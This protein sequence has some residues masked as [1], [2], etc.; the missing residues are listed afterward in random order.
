MNNYTNSDLLVDYIDNNLSLEEKIKVEA[1]LQND[2]TIQ[3]ELDNLVLAK[4]A[5]EYYGIRKQV[6]LIHQNMMAN[7]AEEQPIKKE[8][9]IIRSMV[10]WSIRIAASLLIVMLGLGVYQYATI[11]SDKLFDENYSA[12]TISVTRGE[13]SETFMEKAFQEKK[14]EAVIAAFLNVK[15]ATQKESFIAGHAYLE[16]KNYEKANEAYNAVLLKN[17]ATQQT[18]FN[19]DAQYFLAMSYL[20]NKKIN[21]AKPIF[22]NINNTSTHLYNDKV[23]STF[24]RNLKLLSWKN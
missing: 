2:E 22:E 18:I 16:T 21:L 8:K 11:T 14:Y 23:S 9:G 24:M 1:M 10:K 3:T 4:N 7:N 13:V 20:K 17:K 15:D 19:D 5:I 6:R 12:Y